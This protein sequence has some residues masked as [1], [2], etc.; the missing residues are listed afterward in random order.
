MREALAKAQEVPPPQGTATAEQGKSADLAGL[1]DLPIEQLAKTPV[2][3]GGGPSMDTPV[4]SVTK[5]ASTVGRSAAAVFVITNEMIRRSGATCIPEALRMAPGIDVAHINA[6]TWAISSRGFNGL[7]ANKLLV[8]IDGRTVYVPTSSGVYWDVQDVL[9]ED[10][11]RIEVVRGPGGTLWG[12]N[13]VNGVINVITKTAKD[14]Q[15]TY[16]SAGGG[17]QERMDDGIRYGGKSGDDFYYRLYGKHFERGPG[18]DP[19]GPPEDSWRQGRLGFRTDW[20]LDRD[21]STNLTVQGDCYT[22]ESGMTAKYTSTVPP[23]SWVESGYIDNSGQNVVARLRHVNNEDSDWTLQTYFDNY[24]RGTILNSERVKTFDVDFQYRFPF[25]DR[26]SI[27]CGAGYRDIHEQLP[28]ED[29]FTLS[30]T[31]PETTSTLCSQFVQDEI[32]LI[33]ERLNFILGCKLE[34]NTYTG[35][36]YQPTARLLWTPDRRHTVWSAVSRAVRIPGYEEHGALFSTSPPADGSPVFGRI[37]GNDGIQSETLWAYELGY[38]TQATN[39][40]SYDIATFYNIYGG[41]SKAVVTGPPSL[42]FFPQPTHLILPL[43][44]IN[45]TGAD[46]Y[47]VELATNWSI[48]DHW[49]LSTQYTFLRILTYPVDIAADGGSPKHQI[50]MRS[51]WDLRENVDFDLTFRYVDCLT[52]YDVPSY[53]TMDARLAWRPKKQLELA[54]VGQ[55]LLQDHHQEFGVVP[56]PGYEV[57][58]VPRGV[59]GTVTWRY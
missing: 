59:Y 53:V 56:L 3:S 52:G 13:A 49:R 11:D 5:E 39:Q 41:L 34:E 19:T 7:Y 44:F 10:V 8:L 45:G 25:G 43:T 21:K 37:T 17:T 29:P 22:G 6:N 38:R 57:T 42:E 28:S 31:P 54:V 20:N 18:F 55:N 9:L 47:G 1:L 14:T 30:S 24:A 33:E 12:S 16:A 4:T 15:G 23:F 50:Y 51:S 32:T 2:T 26:N 46:T 27:T 35:L 58:E 48:S 36:E 40:F